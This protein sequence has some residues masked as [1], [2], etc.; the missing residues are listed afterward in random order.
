MMWLL[1]KI[2]EFLDTVDKYVSRNM[3]KYGDF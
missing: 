1:I 3:W 2:W